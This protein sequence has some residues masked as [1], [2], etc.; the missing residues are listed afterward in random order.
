M[1]YEHDPAP[2][3]G[4]IIA[5]KLPSDERPR[6]EVHI[7]SKLGVEGVS[8]DPNTWIIDPSLE[9][10]AAFKASLALGAIKE[11]AQQVIAK[12]GRENI[13][14]FAVFGEDNERPNAAALIST[15]FGEYD[16]QAVHDVFAGEVNDVL[17]RLDS[18]YRL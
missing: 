6:I 18:P 16:F 2:I 5:T 1:S 12:K 7:A 15:E 14:A 11:I 13:L 10:D 9:A 4:G 17:S 3:K 8:V